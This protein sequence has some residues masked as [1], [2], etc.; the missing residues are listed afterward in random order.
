[1]P[2][3]RSMKRAQEWIDG[4]HAVH[5]GERTYESDIRS[6]AAILDEVR[7]AER[8]RCANVPAARA[9]MRRARAKEWFDLGEDQKWAASA[10]VTLADEDEGIA[11]EI[12]QGGDEDGS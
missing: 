8:E 1:M 3:A 10:E 5:G 7:A 9:A 12:R 4:A 6:L 11:A 2:D